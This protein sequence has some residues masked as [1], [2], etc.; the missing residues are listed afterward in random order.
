[1]QTSYSGVGNE[2]KK[3]SKGEIDGAIR[4]SPNPKRQR[5]KRRIEKDEGEGEE[6][7]RRRNKKKRCVEFGQAQ[8]PSHRDRIAQKA[9]RNLMLTYLHAS[10]DGK[11]LYRRDKELGARE[12]GKSLP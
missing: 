8:I 9:G 3:H 12:G 4:E 5:K 11:I 1:M 6:R 7:K 2:R 10:K